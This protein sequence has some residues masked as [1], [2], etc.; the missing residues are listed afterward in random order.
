LSP[1]KHPINLEARVDDHEDRIGD[2]ETRL[3]RYDAIVT[4]LDVFIELLTKHL[5]DTAKRVDDAIEGQEVLKERNENAHRWA[6]FG[7]SFASSVITGVL[8]AVVIY[9]WPLI[10]R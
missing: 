10:V 4:R 8:V 3:D 1:Q 2:L 7:I 6:T 5:E 9:V